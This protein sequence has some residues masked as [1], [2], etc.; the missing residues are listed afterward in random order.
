MQKFRGFFKPLNFLP[1]KISDIKV[2]KNDHFV[3][4]LI[5][6]VLL[7]LG[8]WCY[9]HSFIL[10]R[11]IMSLLYLNLISVNEALLYL[12][13]ISLVVVKY[14]FHRY[15]IYIDW[16]DGPAYH[17]NTYNYNTIGICFL[18]QKIFSHQMKVFKEIN[19]GAN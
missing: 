16:I 10:A 1:A 18:L 4:L 19:W 2:L 11:L 5:L 15:K 8:L 14:F 6:S 13:H 12:V 3:F 9:F 7:S 17:Y